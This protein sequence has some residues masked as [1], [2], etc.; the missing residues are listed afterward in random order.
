MKSLKTALLLLVLV[1][2]VPAFAGQPAPRLKVGSSSGIFGPVSN[3]T[4]ETFAE[5][6]KAGIDAIEISA[7]KLFLDKGM[8]DDKQIEARCRQLKRDLKRAGIEIW[9]VHM[10]Y[11]KE[12]DIS[13]TDEAVRQKSVELNRR[14]LRFCRILSPRIVLF[15]PSWY[16]GRG[17]RDARIAQLVRSVG[18]LLPDAKKIGAEMVIENMLGYELVKDEN[19]ER[20][21]NRTVEEVVHIMS[22]MPKEV[23]AAV[24]TNHI[25]NPEL[26]I[27]ALGTRVKTIHISD[28][29]GRNEC[30]ELPWH[31]RGDNDWVAVLKALYEDA[32]YKGIFMYE[33]RKAEFPELKACYDKMYEQYVQSKQ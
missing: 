30:H 2:G 23:N 10:P 7:S 29:D 27:K 8:T 15:H 9:S 1:I 21:L 26:L 14:V 18:E 24:D 28:G 4:Y 33:V 32:H 6:K 22:L 12:I 5:A 3:W 25:D 11:G 19:Y 31:G 13:Q 20:P 16:L 17:E